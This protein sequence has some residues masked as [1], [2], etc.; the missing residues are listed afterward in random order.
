MFLKLLLQLHSCSIWLVGTEKFNRLKG[1]TL[2]T[3]K[4]LKREGHGA[5][6][7]AADLNLDWLW[8]SGWIIPPFSSPPLMLQ[9]VTVNNQ[10]IQSQEEKV[11][12]VCPNSHYHSKIHLLSIIYLTKNVMG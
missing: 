6:D 1:C 10:K 11:Y 3:E 2:K 12:T 5:A 4:E 8:Y 7:M 9:R